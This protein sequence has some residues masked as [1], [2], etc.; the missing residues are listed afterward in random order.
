MVSVSAWAKEQPF[1]VWVGFA[2][3]TQLWT[4]QELF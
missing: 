2:E 1:E 3:H 4:S